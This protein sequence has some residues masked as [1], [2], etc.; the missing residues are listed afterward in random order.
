MTRIDE[1]AGGSQTITYSEALKRRVRRG[2]LR[3][4]AVST[5]A[6]LLEAIDREDPAD[7]AALAAYAV[8]EAKI[9][10]DVMAQWRADLRM[11]LYDKGV[12]QERVAADEQRL[13]DLLA[14]PDGEPFDVPRLWSRLLDLILEL[15]GSAHQ[16]D[17]DEARRLVSDARELWRMISDR[18]VDWCSGVMNELVLH[19]GEEVVPEMWERI[20]WPLFNWRY[21]KFYVALEA[22]RAYLST[23]E[24]DGAPLELVEYDDRWVLRFDPCGSGGRSMRGEPRDNARSRMEAPFNFKVIEK[25][26]DWTDGKEGV[27]VYCNHCQVVLEHWPMDR[28]GYPVRVVDPPT[29]PAADRESGRTKKC[30]WTMYKDPTAAPEEIYER[31]GRTKPTRFGSSAHRDAARPTDTAAFIGGG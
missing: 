4:Q 18:D 24:R 11:L 27:C 8:D 5:W 7:A 17:W 31:A 10:C 16:Q 26:Y 23:P 2:D 19:A 20:L 6:K 13:I 22:M 21:D 14:L 12:S 30:Q 28:F 1:E 15:Q 9:H 25:A 3:E 29:Y